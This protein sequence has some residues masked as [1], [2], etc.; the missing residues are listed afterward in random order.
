METSK[1]SLEQY[2][3]K[4]NLL[5]PISDFTLDKTIFPN[6]LT[7]KQ[8]MKLEKECIKSSKEYY[9]KRNIAI[10]EYNVK[11]QTG[12]LIPF[13]KLETLILTS[14][15]HEDLEQTQAARRLL[16]KRYGLIYN[17]DI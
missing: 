4:E 15:G 8:R 7:T 2:L 9:D 11:V 12:E 3:A 6:G 14:H 16:Y 5:Y 10:K 13:S 1:I 17:E